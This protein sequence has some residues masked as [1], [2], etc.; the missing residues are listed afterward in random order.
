MNWLSVYLG[1]VVI[2]LIIGIV[3]RKCHA[4]AI[5]WLIYLLAYILV[6]ESVGYY[7]RTHQLNN[8]F[9]FYIYQPIEYI[10][11]CYL[12]AAHF[13]NGG[14]RF[15]TKVVGWVF[16]LFCTGFSIWAW[17][18]SQLKEEPTLIIIIEWI[19]VFPLILYYFYELY[20]SNKIVKLGKQPLFWI[21]VGNFL[22]Y[23]GTF[24]LMG[25]KEE[26]AKVNSQ[27]AEDLFLINTFLNILLYTFWSIGF[28]CLR[29]KI[30][31]FS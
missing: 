30:R 28:L 24:F 11:L 27:L 26:L 1:T 3:V 10:F 23:A 5:Q 25:L 29:I 12:Y 9:L 8:E 4:E 31:Y 22:F 15:W 17:Y 16:V 13:D 20:Q 14:A 18:D 21:S 7:L 19:L 2:T 6:S